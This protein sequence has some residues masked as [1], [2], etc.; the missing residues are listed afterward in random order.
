M[1]H[2]IWLWFSFILFFIC[3]SVFAEV[4]YLNS[5][6]K[7][8]G[9]IVSQDEDKIV[10]SIGEGE[11]AT[12]VT[13]FSDEI[14][15]VEEVEPTVNLEEII[16]TEPSQP[17]ANAQVDQT[18]SPPVLTIDNK[19]EITQPVQV[20][21]K[22]TIGVKAETAITPKTEAITDTGNAQ[23]QNQLQNLSQPLQ[24]EAPSKE[25]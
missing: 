8:T 17:S 14:K 25:Q 7:V 24:Q 2:K 6:N 16:I 23:L 10:V 13:L 21:P 22:E 15:S 4:I 3:T 19:M 12:E 18:Q 11:D 1:K 9:K 5:G 20:P